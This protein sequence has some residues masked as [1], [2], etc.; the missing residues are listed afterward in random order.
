MNTIVVGKVTKKLTLGTKYKS[1]KLRRITI[2]LIALR[3]LTF[4]FISLT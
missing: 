4:I 1:P 2:V 3:A